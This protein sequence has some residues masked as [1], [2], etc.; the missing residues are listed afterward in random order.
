MREEHATGPKKA[1]KHGPNN[2]TAGTIKWYGRNDSKITEGA[3]NGLKRGKPTIKQ[4]PT[5]ERSKPIK[6][7]KS[8]HRSRHKRSRMSG[9]MHR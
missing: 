2:T 3:K 9:K 1:S 4:G 5:L 6:N 7:G 8:K